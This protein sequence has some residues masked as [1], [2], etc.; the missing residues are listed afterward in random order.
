[1]NLPTWFY[2]R[3]HRMK[4]LQDQSK[5]NLID[6]ILLLEAEALDDKIKE[7]SAEQNVRKL[8]VGGEV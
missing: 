3:T 2:F 6:R 8:N 7:T 1:M 5:D 4:E